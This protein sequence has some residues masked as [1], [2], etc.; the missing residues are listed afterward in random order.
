VLK[1]EKTLLPYARRLRRDMTPEERKLWYLFLR[2]YP[3]KFYRQRIID[4][5]IV[6]FFC[7]RGKVVVEIDGSQHYEEEGRQADQERDARMRSLGL[8]VLR[9]SNREI[10]R[11]FDAVCENIRQ[12]VQSRILNES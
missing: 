10:N 2:K 12:T 9:F 3:V 5:F 11:E 4:A 8:A 1:K 6:D 7:E